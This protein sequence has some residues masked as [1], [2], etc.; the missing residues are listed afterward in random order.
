MGIRSARAIKE[1]VDH[2]LKF[3]EVI[4]VLSKFS[5]HRFI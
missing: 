2:T 5:L 4:E 3:R 1:M